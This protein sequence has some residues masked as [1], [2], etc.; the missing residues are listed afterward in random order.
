M[1]ERVGR[2]LGADLRVDGIGLDDDGTTCAGEVDGRF[3]ESASDAPAPVIARN[4]EAGDGPHCVVIEVWMGGAALDDGASAEP[5]RSLRGSTAHQ[6]T[7]VSP[8]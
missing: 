2:H 1:E 8:S 3:G 5:G 4:D 7:G 6:P